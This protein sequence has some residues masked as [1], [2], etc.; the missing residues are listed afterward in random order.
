MVSLI[1]KGVTAT[2]IYRHYDGKNEL[3][4]AVMDEGLR[5]FTSYLRRGLDGETPEERLRLAGQAYLDFA[6]DAFAKAGR[7]SGALA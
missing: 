6:L 2:A 5:I 4:A 7:A 3:I 1:I